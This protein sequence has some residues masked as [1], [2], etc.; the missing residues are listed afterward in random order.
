[1]DMDVDTEMEISDTDDAARHPAHQATPMTEGVDEADEDQ[2]DE[3]EEMDTFF[4][5]VTENA[6]RSVFGLTEGL[7]LTEEEEE[8]DEDEEKE[9]M[10]VEVDMSLLSIGRYVPSSTFT[11]VFLP[12]FAFSRKPALTFKSLPFDHIALILLSRRSHSSCLIAVTFQ[13]QKASLILRK[14]N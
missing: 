12:T 7:A 2:P 9:E 10:E 11:H 5:H 8:E 14:K 6:V 3:E 13:L 4:N 1:M